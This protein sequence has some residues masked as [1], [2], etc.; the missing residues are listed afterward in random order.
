MSRN[1]DLTRSTNE[2]E[3]ELSLSLDGKGMSNVE[4]GIGFLDHMLNSFARHGR[5]DLDLTCEGD[6]EVDDHHTVEDCAICLGNAFDE[7][8]GDR[9]GIAR[10]GSA[11]AP[12]DE[13]LARSVVDLSGRPS[14]NI[15]LQLERE[16]IGGLSIENI[17]HLF[18]TLA[19]RSVSSIH[20]DV[21][22]GTNDHHR[23]EAAFKSL[24]LAL[25]AAVRETD[26]DRAR[27]TKGTLQ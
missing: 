7:A 6:L 25:N 5:F 10:F 23:V 1:A 21:V 24:A 12:L 9:T 26:D 22:K 8:L 13:A 18:R 16:R 3:I 20:V 11:F 15:C 4:T 14:P 19:N 17:P 2:T 27:S